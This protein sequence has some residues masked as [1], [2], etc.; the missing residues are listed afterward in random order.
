[1]ATSEHIVRLQSDA[2]ELVVREAARRGVEPDELVDEIVRTDLSQLDD[3]DLETTLSRAAELRS[4]LP[5]I[6]GLALAR[7]ARNELEQRGA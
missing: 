1:M 6:D 7:E 3:T 2:Y 5:P 4:T